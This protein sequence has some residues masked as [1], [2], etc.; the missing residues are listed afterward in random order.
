MRSSWVSSRGLAV[1]WVRMGASACPPEAVLMQGAL[2]TSTEVDPQVFGPS[3]DTVLH[4]TSAWP[5]GCTA[6]RRISELTGKENTHGLV[7]HFLTCK[8]VLLR[9]HAHMHLRATPSLEMQATYYYTHVRATPSLEMQATYYY[10]HVQLH[11]DTIYF[12]W[13]GVLPKLEGL[14]GAREAMDSHNGLWEGGSWTPAGTT[15]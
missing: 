1:G 11:M 9:V 2:I 7:N 5:W 8:P 14:K 15:C 12:G 4:S 13:C 3:H 10:T 6:E